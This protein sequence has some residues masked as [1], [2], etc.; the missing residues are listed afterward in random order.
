MSAETVFTELAARVL[1]PEVRIQRNFDDNHDV[2]YKLAEG[3][4]IR[5]GVVPGTWVDDREWDKIEEQLRK[6]RAKLDEE[7]EE[8]EEE[9]DEG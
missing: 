3:E 7:L 5:L 2:A 9:N 8:R 6:M 1:G 4:A